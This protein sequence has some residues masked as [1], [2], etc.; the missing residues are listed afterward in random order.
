MYTFI[1][2]VFKDDPGT[3]N[4]FLFYI[5]SG[6]LGFSPKKLKQNFRMKFLL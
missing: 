1:C 2:E 6:K 4:G 3:V 5:R